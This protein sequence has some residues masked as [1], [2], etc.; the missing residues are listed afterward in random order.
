MESIYVFKNV[1]SSVKRQ[2][3]IYLIGLGTPSSKIIKEAYDEL[4]EVTKNHIFINKYMI[5]TKPRD[6]G[7]IGFHEIMK[8]SGKSAF[9]RIITDGLQKK[10]N[11][12]I[13]SKKMRITYYLNSFMKYLVLNCFTYIIV[14]IHLNLV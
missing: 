8:I 5:M 9:L 11:S 10:Y 7:F 6:I 3:Y 4:Y 13:G 14:P 12:D 2:I 1:P